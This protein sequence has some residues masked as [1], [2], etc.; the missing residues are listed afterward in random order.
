VSTWT[1]VEQGGEDCLASLVGH[2]VELVGVLARSKIPTLCGVDV[3]DAEEL[4]G[5][6][7][8]ARGTLSRD[9]IHAP[10]PGAPIAA[11]RGPGVSYSLREP[12]GALARPQ[13]LEQGVEG[14]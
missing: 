8:V 14:A 4:S 13:R 11:G 10:Q 2:P 7:V 9:E 6:R 5:Q 1:R 12:T 3:H